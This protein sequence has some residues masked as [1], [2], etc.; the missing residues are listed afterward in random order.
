MSHINEPAKY[1]LPIGR[2]PSS[3][4]VEGSVY[5]NPFPEEG[6]PDGAARVKQL[7]VTIRAR[8]FHGLPK[9]PFMMIR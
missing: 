4:L 9:S 6:N 7:K 1:P 2:N 5:Q 8:C 3:Q